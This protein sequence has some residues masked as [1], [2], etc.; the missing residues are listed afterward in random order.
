MALE[1][2]VLVTVAVGIGAVFAGIVGYKI[3][4][5]KKPEII[6]KAKESVADTKKKASE[7][8]QGARESFRKGYASA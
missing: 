2:G 4:K 7:I 3:L 8:A 6:K 1:K 5:K